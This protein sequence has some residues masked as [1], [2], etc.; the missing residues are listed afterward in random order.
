MWTAV[1][2]FATLSGSLLELSAWLGAEQV[3]HIAMEAT[4][5]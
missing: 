4:G 5:V 1:R 2:T 3:T